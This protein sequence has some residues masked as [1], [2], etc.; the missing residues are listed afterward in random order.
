MV[1]D[2]SHLPWLGAVPLG[3]GRVRFRVWAPDA[4]QAV[5]VLDGQRHAML[6]ETDG[7]FVVALP[8]QA[9]ARY[10]YLF[11]NDVRVPDPV[12]RWQPDG[13]HGDSTVLDAD[14]YVWQTHDWRGR[15]WHESVI[16]ELHAGTC[17]G[18]RGI[19][20]QLPQ[21]AAWGITA[22]E[23]MPLSQ[24][25]GERNWGYDGVLPYAPAAAY[26]HPDELKALI[27]QAH[28]LGISVLLDVV[29]NHFGPDGNYL[30]RYASAFFR[31]DIATPW[32]EAID[33]R[34]EPV[35]RYFIDNALMWLQDYR[36]DGLRLDAVHAI[37]PRGF[38]DLLRKQLRNR[39]PADRHVHLI[40]ENEAN[41]ASL[42]S[43]DGYTAQWNDDFH[44]ALHVLMTGEQEGYYR[45]FSNDPAA[46]LARVLEQGFAY[47][48]EHTPDGHPR[49]EP[50]AHLPPSRFVV[51][52]QNHDQIGNRAH[53]DR[54]NTLVS[55]AAM[56]AAT[57]LVALSPM[58]P[59]FFMGEPWGCRAPF[60]FFT[61]YP[62][63]LD[64]QVREGRRREFVQFAAF[65]DAAS[66][67]TIP[68]PNAPTTFQRS[69]ADIGQAQ[70]AEGCRWA[71]WFAGLLSLRR[72]QLVPRLDRARAMHA[73][74][75]G[76]GA[77]E[78]WWSLGDTR[79]RIAFNFGNAPVALQQLPD[80]QLLHAENVG[81]P[82]LGS[83]LP[84]N[85]FIAELFGSA[86]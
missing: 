50:S 54:L 51:F 6:A 77:L 69:I 71:E 65:T 75:I 16:Y 73:R 34:V 62:P 12:S 2:A 28:A 5:L 8:C 31:D 11:D 66:R 70:Q 4:R 61:D 53:G 33:F 47:Q 19:C 60:L 48:G 67:A 43:D 72:Q 82:S 49:G 86:P 44:N 25:P 1:A 39:L 17:G 59:M 57:A 46:Q 15:P 55:E 30:H 18:Y 26:G 41:Q 58:I 85:G 80:A 84:P 79:L 10:H 42:L 68:D 64:E 13:V 36:F 29:Y 81:R 40:L 21:L 38:L 76:D 78:A 3:D 9:G 14:A 7:C 20:A 45:G 24:F 23:L 22:I 74:V 63:P 83:D 37:R 56:R 35:Q 27:D 52:L 32:G